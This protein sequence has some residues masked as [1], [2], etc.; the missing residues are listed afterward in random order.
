[1]ERGNYLGSPLGDFLEGLAAE[2]HAPGGGSAAALT[3]AFAAGL[4][5]M[6]ARGSRA[7]WDEADGVAAQA[8]NLR[9]RASPLASDD[10]AAWD[11]ALEALAAT[12]DTSTGEGN[13]DGGRGDF[14]LEQKLERAAAVPLEI[15]ELGADV[16]ALAAYAAEL[17]NA[18]LRADAAAA[19]ALAAGGA[20][21]A[22]HLVEVNLGMREG[23][24]R[25]ARA[26]ASERAAAE[27]AERLLASIR[28]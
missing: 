11:E 28:R 14:A 22:A 8:L 25:L 18:A 23:D 12:V 1:M 20:R 27:A 9:D 6:V 21:A 17:G 15:A 3:V 13:G 5:A 16:A 24:E 26:R 2:G 10:A 19:A 4:V 7:T